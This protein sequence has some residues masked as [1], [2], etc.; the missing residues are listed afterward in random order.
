MCSCPRTSSCLTWNDPTDPRSTVAAMHSTEVYFLFD[1]DTLLII[2]WFHL[3]SFSQSVCLRVWTV[4][5]SPQHSERAAFPTYWTLFQRL[6][7]W[8]HR[9]ALH[10]WIQHLSMSQVFVGLIGGHM[11]SSRSEVSSSVRASRRSPAVWCWRPSAAPAVSVLVGTDTRCASRPSSWC[12]R[13]LWTRRGFG[14]WSP[15]CPGRPAGTAGTEPGPA[16]E[17]CCAAP[18]DKLNLTGPEDLKPRRQEARTDSA[19][20]FFSLTSLMF[21]CKGETVWG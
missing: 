7:M 1:E 15:V 8:P 9:R 12:E 14:G 17:A 2:D 19:A 18:S 4:W 3:I 10:P 21:D 11:T 13:S 6:V 16:S 20:S 5:T